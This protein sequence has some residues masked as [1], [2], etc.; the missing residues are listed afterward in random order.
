M[1]KITLFE[2]SV[3]EAENV[4]AGVIPAVAAVFIMGAKFGAGVTLV[5]AAIVFSRP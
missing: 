5:G 1:N 4:S 3:D 2:L